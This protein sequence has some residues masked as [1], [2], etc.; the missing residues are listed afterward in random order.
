MLSVIQISKGQ[1]PEGN[2]LR[3]GCTSEYD[4]Y[5]KSS[6]DIQRSWYLDSFIKDFQRAIER[7]Y[8]EYDSKY[9]DFHNHIS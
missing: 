6:G 9:E 5:V 2:V 8:F 4:F 7:K 3:F 1:K